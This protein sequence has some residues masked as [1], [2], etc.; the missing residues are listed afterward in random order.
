M[1]T[2]FFTRLNVAQI[3]LVED[4]DMI[5][6]LSTDRAD[7]LFNVGILPGR[8]GR[9]LAV[10]DRHRSEPF[11][12][13]F[14]KSPIAVSNKISVKTSAIIAAMLLVVCESDISGLRGRPTPGP[15]SGSR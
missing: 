6:A 2:I 3:R 1:N 5:V 10:P 11:A 7:E 15:G 13:S 4:D 9:R 12:E 14:A 8:A